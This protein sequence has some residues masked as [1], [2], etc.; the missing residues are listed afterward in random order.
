MAAQNFR[1]ATQE[2]HEKVG[3]FIRRLE[4]LFK[5]A[6]GRDPI[7]WEARVTLLYGQLQEGMKHQIMESP[8]VLGATN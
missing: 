1:H 2:D 8:A 6:Y 7:S 4:Q 5:L 3:D